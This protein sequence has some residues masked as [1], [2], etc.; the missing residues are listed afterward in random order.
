MMPLAMTLAAPACKD[1]IVLRIGLVTAGS[2]RQWG[3]M[4]AHQMICHLSDS[5]CAVIGERKVSPTR[6][7]LPRPILKW[8]VLWAPMQ[9]PHNVR[10]RPEIE[11]GMG[12]TPPDEFER[13]RRA[14]LEAMERFCSAPDSKRDHIR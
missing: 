4:S 7:F 8:L 10:A 12:G 14:L 2:Q 11:Q 13:D 6:L 3:K 9:W 5:F 1:S